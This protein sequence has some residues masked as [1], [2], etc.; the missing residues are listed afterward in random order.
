M[1]KLTKTFFILRAKILIPCLTSSHNT[2]YEILI[3]TLKMSNLTSGMFLFKIT[4]CVHIRSNSSSKYVNRF[5]INTKVYYNFIKTS[6]HKI[7]IE[8]KFHKKKC[9]VVLCSNSKLQTVIVTTVKH[10][11]E[12]VFNTYA[13]PE[14]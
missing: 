4:V 6:R 12:N 8:A 11:Q 10:R 2:Y 3:K 5:G 1:R 13:L 7:K 14:S 9:F